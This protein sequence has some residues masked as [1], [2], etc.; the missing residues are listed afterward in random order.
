M[1]HLQG[2]GLLGFVSNAVGHNNSRIEVEF[3]H[4]DTNETVPTIRLKAQGQHAA[5]EMP[6][7][8]ITENT[9][10]C[11]KVC[12]LDAN[13]RHACTDYTSVFVQ[14]KITGSQS[15]GKLDHLGVRAQ[16]LGTIELRKSGV[17]NHQFLSL[18]MIPHH[19]VY[20]IV[21]GWNWLINHACYARD[22]NV[23]DLQVC[24]RGRHPTVPVATNGIFRS[25]VVRAVTAVLLH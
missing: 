16:L 17:K 19:C 1:C 10:V 22:C 20:V 23:T 13:F 14:V 18:S 11:G 12:L 8:V 9:K 25:D 15:G 7:Y 4:P 3:T 5:E 2:K 21:Y 6:L 24:D